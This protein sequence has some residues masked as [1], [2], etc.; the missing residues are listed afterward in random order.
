MKFS[1]TEQ[2]LDISR[3]SLRYWKKLG[4]LSSPDD[5]K[6]LDFVDLI[7]A[8]FIH[9][10]RQSGISLQAVRSA[11]KY[12]PAWQKEL[13]LYAQNIL[14]TRTDDG[15]CES[16]LQQ[17]LLPLNFNIETKNSAQ[18]I[19]FS[20]HERKKISKK[21]QVLHKLETQYQS[22]L[23]TEKR[24]AGEMLRILQQMLRIDDTCL[25]AWIE[26][27]N[28]YFNMDKQKEAYAAYE[29]ALE[30]DPVCEEALYN[31][32]NLHFKAKRYAAAI[33]CFQKC[34]QLGSSFY[35][36]YYNFGL[37]LL[38]IGEYEAG[39]EVLQEYLY[40]DPD[41][42]WGEQAR[43]YIEDAR[44][45]MQA[46]RDNNSNSQENEGKTEQSLGQGEGNLSVLGKSPNNVLPL[47]P[48]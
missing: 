32:A 48:C 3:H 13:A 39:I 14:A 1:E 11:V 41:S 6:D 7:R 2:K 29:K 16:G 46:I 40:H 42:N 25:A 38:H 28:L 36:I 37:V 27:G 23:A 10:C 45:E 44:A 4:L 34:L 20:R 30:L 9:Q 21:E 43:Q 12:R 26:L 17:M 35:E 33:H 8:R 22:M 19:A 5:G 18:T 47:F 15:L 31:L 24:D